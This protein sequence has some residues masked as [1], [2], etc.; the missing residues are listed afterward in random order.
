MSTTQPAPLDLFSRII[1]ALIKAVLGHGNAIGLERP[2]T[3][4]IA[5]YIRRLS[6]R[7]LTCA[8][9]APLPHRPR[10][11][12][13]PASPPKPPAP[14]TLPTSH[15]WLR[16]LIDTHII[17]GYA[18]QLHHQITTPEFLLLF[19][20]NPAL[21]RPLRP[22]CRMLGIPLPPS[23]RLTPKPRPNPPPKSPNPASPP[24]PKAKSILPPRHLTPPQT[25]KFTPQP[26]AN[27]YF[28]NFPE[29]R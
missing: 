27:W 10:T 14:Y 23:L 1:D 17:T 15:N 22:L 25:P 26:L 13:R 5:S 16:R 8:A 11:Q 18:S 6:R 21:G 7:F 28:A 29:R 4:F 3:L 2:L 9:R 20:Q 12:I 24:R 19:S